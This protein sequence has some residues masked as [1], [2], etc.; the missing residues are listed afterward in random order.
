MA[1]SSGMQ[2]ALG[3]GAS[4]LCA[5]IILVGGVVYHNELRVQLYALTGAE[6]PADAEG[7][8]TRQPSAGSPRLSDAEYRV[9]QAEARAAEA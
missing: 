5:A 7:G 4:W 2:N 3:E 6:M 8:A 9:R 1:L